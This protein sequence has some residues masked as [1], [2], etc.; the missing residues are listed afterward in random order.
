M[1]YYKPCDI[2]TDVTANI[3]A[4]YSLLFSKTYLHEV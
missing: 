1:H 4:L 2:I 3:S